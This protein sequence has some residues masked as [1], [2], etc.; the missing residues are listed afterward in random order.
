[1]QRFQG[2]LSRP[3]GP[4]VPL[5]AVVPVLGTVQ[6]TINALSTLKTTF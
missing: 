3:G 6:L 1:M 2:G 5:A 4:G